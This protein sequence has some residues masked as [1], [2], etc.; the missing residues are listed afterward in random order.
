MTIVVGWVQ[1]GVAVMG[2]DSLTSDG[3]AVYPAAEPKI[4]CIAGGTALIGVGGFVELGHRI[5]REAEN[6]PVYYPDDPAWWADEIAGLVRSCAMG[7]G[8]KGE[9]FGE[10]GTPDHVG[11]LAVPGRLWDLSPRGFALPVDGCAA[12]ASGSYFAMG[13]LHALQGSSYRGDEIVR[14]A[15]EAAIEYSPGCGGAVQLEVLHEG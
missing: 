9:M 10:D 5:F 7:S 13:A 12:V 14:K 3:C 11:L 2:A 8:G 1:P 4:A 15:V 6:W